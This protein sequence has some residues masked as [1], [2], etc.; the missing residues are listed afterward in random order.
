MNWEAI[1]AIGEILGA[2]AVVAT[3]AYLAV[4]VRQNSRATDVSTLSLA[5]NAFNQIDTLIATNS[6]MARIFRL[7]EVYLRP[8]CLWSAARWRSVK[9]LKHIKRLHQG[10]FVCD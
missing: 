9:R 8:T 4:Q 2:I 3:L 6:N 10:N 5:L 7:C 1:G